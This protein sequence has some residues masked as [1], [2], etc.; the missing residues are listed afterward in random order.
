MFGF[1]A[2]NFFAVMIKSKDLMIG[3]FNKG[4][5][6]RRLSPRQTFLDF[7]VS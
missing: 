3:Q 1:N 5:P 2:P 7:R 4:V 6:G